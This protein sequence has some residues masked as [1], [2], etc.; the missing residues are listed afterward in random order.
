MF[1]LAPWYKRTQND[2]E[3]DRNNQ[4]VNHLVHE[5]AIHRN[6]F[7]LYVD[8][9]RANTSYIEFGRYNTD[10]IASSLTFL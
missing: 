8:F 5:K 3:L 9:E 7:S 6:I 2:Q 1:G 10:A 4:I